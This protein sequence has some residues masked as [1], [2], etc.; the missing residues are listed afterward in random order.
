MS[1][2][3]GAEGAQLTRMEGMAVTERRRRC[4]RERSRMQSGSQGGSRHSAVP[5]EARRG[6]GWGAERLGMAGGAAESWPTLGCRKSPAAGETHLGRWG[7][8][9]GAGPRGGPS[10]QE[11][12]RLRLRDVS[13]V[14]RSGTE[15]TRIAHTLTADTSEPSEV[16]PAEL[17]REFQA[18]GRPR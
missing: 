9:D 5:P 7:R 11:P 1:L 12:W 18:P 8:A 17:G 16:S 14:K 10:P 4:E 2:D 6:A 3:A 15:R 13:A